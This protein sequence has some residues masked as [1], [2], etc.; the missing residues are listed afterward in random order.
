[1]LG[2]GSSRLNKPQARPRTE[3]QQQEG[4][5][6][7]GRLRE[8]KSVLED[9]KDWYFQ[10]KAFISGANPDAG[11]V[12]DTAGLNDQP[13]T[14]AKL[15]AAQIRRRRGSS[16]ARRRFAEEGGKLDSMKGKDGALCA[17][18]KNKR[19]N[20]EPEAKRQ[21]PDIVGV[22]GNYEVPDDEW[23]FILP[24]IATQKAASADRKSSKSKAAGADRGRQA[25]HAQKRT[26]GV[27]G[28]QILRG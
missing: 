14:M 4:S 12:L 23:E 21:R 10:F 6:S 16:H 18:R 24:G 26:A 19:A 27:R 11:T 2:Q 8:F 7:L 3:R 13:V 22:E 20:D 25:H 1:M 5:K 28:T 15:G 9:W 17:G